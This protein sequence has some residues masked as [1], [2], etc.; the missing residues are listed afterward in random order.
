MTTEAQTQTQEQNQQEQPQAQ[1]ESQENTLQ[2][3]Y[4]Q[5]EERL[6]VLR[7]EIARK[8][9]A[10]ESFD[11]EAAE[12]AALNVTHQDTRKKVNAGAITEET[13]QVLAGIKAIIAASRLEELLGE[14]VTSVI[15]FQEPGTGD[16]GPVEQLVFNRPVTRRSATSGANKSPGGNSTGTSRRGRKF[17]APDGKVVTGREVVLQHASEGVLNNSL[18]AHGSGRWVTKPEFLE[19]ALTNAKAKGIVFQEVTGE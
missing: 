10:G 9:T 4:N 17:R 14:P 13:A 1:G 8:V 19:D 11:A 3:Q 15:Y 12:L 18:V 16:N 7:S 5:E 6:N 2:L